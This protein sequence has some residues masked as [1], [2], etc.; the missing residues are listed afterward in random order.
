MK[1]ACPRGQE[2]S[3]FMSALFLKELPPDVKILFAHL[4]H[5]R[6]KELAAAA[7]QL[8]AMRTSPAAVA[9]VELESGEVAAVTVSRPQRS[10]LAP[11]G[12]L[13]APLLSG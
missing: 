9:T 1:E 5:T 10:P 11:L 8:M 12:P 4:D 2:D 6:L 13:P 3:V 7:D